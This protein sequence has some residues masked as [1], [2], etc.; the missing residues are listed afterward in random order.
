[1]INTCWL[2]RFCLRYFYFIIV[3]C[4]IV[5]SS[6]G[7]SDWFLDRSDFEVS[8][9]TSGLEAVMPDCDG[10][11]KLSSAMI[12]ALLPGSWRSL[13]STTLHYNTLAASPKL[14]SI[15]IYRLIYARNATQPEYAPST[16]GSEPA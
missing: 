9:Q 16:E 1:M 11:I 2:R 8:G 3:A 7:L 5:I 14:P 10:E 13:L 12:P 15:L 6:N 4:L